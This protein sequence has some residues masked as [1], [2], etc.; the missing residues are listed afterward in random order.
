MYER[1]ENTWTHKRN[2]SKHANG[3]YKVDDGQDKSAM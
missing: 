2:C 3:D 1:K